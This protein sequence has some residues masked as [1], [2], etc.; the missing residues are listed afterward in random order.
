MVA[1]EKAAVQQDPEA[2]ARAIVLRQLT[3]SPKSLGSNWRIN[4]PRG[5]YR[6]KLLRSS[7]TVLKKFN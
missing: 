6:A 5:R 4:W 3:N 2:L 7:W 1:R